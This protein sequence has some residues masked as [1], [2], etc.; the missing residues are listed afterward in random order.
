MEPA[1]RFLHLQ[2]GS[3]HFELD[4]REEHHQ[5]LSSFL[6]SPWQKSAHF[7]PGS[8]EH[9][10]QRGA[11]LSQRQAIPMSYGELLPSCYRG[12][13]QESVQFEVAPRKG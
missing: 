1:P 13:Q 12:L 10:R 9:F 3:V 2:V 4:F 11:L 8:Q 6:R 5:H 7:E